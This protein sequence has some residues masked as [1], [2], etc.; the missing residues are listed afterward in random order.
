MH[1]VLRAFSLFLILI[2]S[3]TSCG[4]FTTKDEEVNT[5]KV[6]KVYISIPEDKLQYLY[7]SVSTDNYTWCMIEKGSWHGDVEIKVRGDSSRMRRKKSFAL[8]IDGKKYMLERGQQNGG[9]Y[10]RI[11]M[12]AYQ[13]AGVTACDT[14]S[15]ALF[16]ND[17]YLGCYN[18]II[19]YDP[20]EMD[21][22]LYKCWFSAI[23]DMGS[24]H[25]LSSRSEKKFPKDG[26]MSNL[27]YLVYACSSLSDADWNEFV[28]KHLDI[29]KTATYMVV[30][31]FLTVTDT[32]RTNYYIHF[33]GKYRIVPWDNEVC[34]LKDRAYYALCTDNQLVNRLG[35]VPEFKTAYNQKMQE[36]FTGGGATCILDTLSA[37]ASAMF[38]NLSTAMKSDPVYAMSYSQFMEE[39]AYVL[40]YLDKTS[41]RAAETD[42]LILH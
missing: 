30:H 4:E 38:D 41:G 25:P 42:K 35:A 34:M 36:L 3:L 16:L 12:R 20:D 11:A 5:G 27:E 7:N 22:E 6:S 13:L 24:N 21:G 18:L 9:I 37:E 29:D 19:Y 1:K 40:N 15:V 10:N 2:I 33:D 23:A 28:N 31:D 32:T 17:E 39:K 14:E 8:K 26:D